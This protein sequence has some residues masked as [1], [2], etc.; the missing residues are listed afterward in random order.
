VARQLI[1]KQADHLGSG[2]SF[3]V[4]FTAGSYQLNLTAYEENV[5]NSI[6]AILLT[7][8]GERCLEPQFGSGLHQFL[9]RQMD[10]TLKGEIMDSVKTS[11]LH[12]EP[13]ITVLSVTVNFADIP[14]GFIEV[15]VK[16]R[17]NQTNTRHNYVFPFHLKEGTNLR[18]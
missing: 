9:F 3:P 5:N 4:T 17:Y 18:K 8:R 12:N 13:R 15:I 11:L 14:N 7:R 2:W 10:E 6:N 16:Y 1:N